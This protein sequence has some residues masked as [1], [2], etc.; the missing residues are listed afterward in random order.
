M[1]YTKENERVFHCV[2]RPNRVVDFDLDSSEPG[3]PQSTEAG[4]W[5]IGD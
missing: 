4:A 3:A 1:N 5:E 2:Q